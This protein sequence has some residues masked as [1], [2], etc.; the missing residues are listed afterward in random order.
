[1]MI[2]KDYVLIDDF[3]KSTEGSTAGAHAVGQRA[4]K[5]PGSMPGQSE[6]EKRSIFSN[7]VSD[8]KAD[9]MMGKSVDVCL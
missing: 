8:A 4:D 2:R 7:Q 1:M 9:L 3:R 6:L 5:Q